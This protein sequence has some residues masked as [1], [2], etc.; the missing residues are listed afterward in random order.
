[1]N[2]NRRAWRGPTSIM[3]I[4][5]DSDSLQQTV[6]IMK[7]DLLDVALATHLTGLSFRYSGAAAMAFEPLWEFEDGRK[8]DFGF[9][10]IE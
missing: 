4:F 7:L 10:F 6:M 9:G 1:M 2:L 8:L 3:G 5:Y